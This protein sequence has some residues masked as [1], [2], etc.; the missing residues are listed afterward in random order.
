MRAPTDPKARALGLMLAVLAAAPALAR[1]QCDVPMAAWQTRE[2]VQA[3]ASQRGWTVRRIKID[4]G[5]YEVEGRDTSGRAFEAK[6][7]P[8][9]LKVVAEKPDDD[10]RHRRRHEADGD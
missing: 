4:D 10:D 3:M 1:E 7:D 9:T 6:I 5:C 2:A 8:Q